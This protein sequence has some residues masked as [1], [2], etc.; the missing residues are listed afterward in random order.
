MGVGGS[1]PL[2]CWEGKEEEDS[3]SPPFLYLPRIARC[4][5][6]IQDDMYIYIRVNC[7]ISFT[8]F[9]FFYS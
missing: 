1:S 5:Y 2:P 9:C 8:R 7:G 3:P 6:I 4:F